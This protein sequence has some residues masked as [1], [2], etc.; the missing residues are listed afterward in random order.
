M[1]RLLSTKLNNSSHTTLD[2]ATYGY[3][4][5]NERTA[6]TNAA[7]AYVSYTYDAIG[8]VK[9]ADSSTNS[10]D[11]GYLYDTAWNLNYRTNNGSLETFTV[12]TKNQLTNATPVG[13]QYYDSNGNLTNRPNT[14]TFY[15]YDDEN[16]LIDFYDGLMGRETVFIYDGLGRLR[17][18]QEYEGAGSRPGE[19][20]QP[21]MTP[22]SETRYVYDGWRVIQ[23]RDGNNTP[24]VSYTR[25]TD[26]SGSLEGAGGIGGLLARSHGYASGN[27]S[28]H[29]CYHADGNGN[30]TCLV[31]SSQALAASYRY[32]PYGN[33]I[34][35]SGTLAG[36]NVYRFSSKE[37]HANSGLYY[38]GYRWYAPNLQRWLNRDP[39][40]EQGGI[41]LYRCFLNHPTGKTDAYGLFTAEEQACMER[42][43]EDYKECRK[44]GMDIYNSILNK[45]MDIPM[46][47]HTRC[48]E[49]S[50]LLRP[51]CHV[52]CTSAFMGGWTGLNAFIACWNLG[53]LD[54]LGVQ[55]DSC[56][57]RSQCPGLYSVSNPPI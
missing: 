54:A 11:R 32:D 8:Q 12:D 35:S 37:I 13:P 10:E 3:N 31:N 17:V 50:I 34:S 1:A 41:N 30:I 28:T 19:G 23:E 47:C 46:V 4:R 56:V 49:V 36:A 38:Y 42:A 51:A 14:L 55:L 24:L 6:C 18:R 53:C 48:A 7:N 22:V 16:R 40:E 39:I 15:E 21:G 43:R 2:A 45:L 52:L 33:L 44:M 5:G 27:W 57:D 25:G 20:P 29:N 26:L 9:V